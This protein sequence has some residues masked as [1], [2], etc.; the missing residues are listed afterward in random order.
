[1]PQPAW[2]VA[3]SAAALLLVHATAAA[4]PAAAAVPGSAASAGAPALAMHRSLRL[5]LPDM[6]A[7]PPPTVPE[8]FNGW[9][10]APAHSVVSRKPELPL[11]PCSMCHN[12][13]KL[14]TTVRTFKVAPPPD[15]AP[16]AGVLR[17]GKGQMWCLDCHYPQDR[18]FLRTLDGKKL[19]FD[20]SPRQ[21]GQCHS[22]RYR[23]WVFGAHGKRAAASW[24][25]ERQL[26][27][28]THCHNPHDPK[29]PPRAAAK[30]P[31]LR[32]GLQ[33]MADSKHPAP[34]PWQRTK[35]GSAGGRTAQQP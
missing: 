15:G 8:V 18:E 25:G 30:P 28:C 29:I 35:E 11:Y 33:P 7:L 4:Q 6:A 12:L 2:R 14:N 17:H 34:L 21:C 31:P 22:A 24:Q 27:A 26:Y 16:H 32:A 23:D 20:D 13:Q 9:P 3:L 10:G 5:P 19:D 1:M